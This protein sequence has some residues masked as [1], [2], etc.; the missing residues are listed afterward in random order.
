MRTNCGATEG[1]SVESGSA[2]MIRE[3]AGRMAQCPGG[4]G[5]RVLVLAWGV[6]VRT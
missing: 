4:F 5:F 3:Y 1:C 6:N 2:W